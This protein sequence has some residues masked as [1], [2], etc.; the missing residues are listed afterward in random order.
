MGRLHLSS[1]PP[2]KFTG[3]PLWQ[4]ITRGLAWTA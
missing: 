3:E 1:Q 4:L 2:G